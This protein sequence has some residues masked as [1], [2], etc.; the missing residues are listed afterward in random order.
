MNRVSADLMISDLITALITKIDSD[1]TREGL[2]DSPKR[3]A[4]FYSEWITTGDPNFPVT[5]FD[6]ESLDEMV[7]V[8]EIPFYSLCE[9]HMLP[10]FGTASVAYIPSTKIVGLSKI[11]R[12]VQHYARRL[13]NQ[14]RM[15]QQIAD[16]LEEIIKPKGTAV[17]LRARHL[18]TEMRGIK[19]IGNETITSKL[20]G[21]LKTNPATRAEYFQLTSAT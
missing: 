12:I 10:F 19:S 21:V 7:I 11:P 2:R 14:E 9:H 5:T 20:K 6:S 3:I 17:T 8:R 16:F 15:T 1:P 18:C 13:Q 4:H